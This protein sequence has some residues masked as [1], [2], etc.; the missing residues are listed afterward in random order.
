MAKQISARLAKA[1]A[2]DD[3]AEDRGMHADD[4][5][6]CHTCQTWATEAHLNSD[7]HW[8]AIGLPNGVVPGW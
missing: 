5:R 1:L 8:K 3:D 6:T 2:D 4:R 7:A